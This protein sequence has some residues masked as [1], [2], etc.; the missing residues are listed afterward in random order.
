MSIA[1]HIGSIATRGKYIWLSATNLGPVEGYQCSHLTSGFMTENSLSILFPRWTGGHL[2]PLKFRNKLRNWQYLRYQ[3]SGILCPRLCLWIKK[4][5]KCW[6]H[7]LK[8]LLKGGLKSH[9]WCKRLWRTQWYWSCISKNSGAPSN[10]YFCLIFGSSN[11]L[12]IK[13]FSPQIFCL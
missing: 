1:T 11:I 7:Y 6:K 4:I 12:I 3:F 13:D 10:I 8:G 2:P 9:I 5:W